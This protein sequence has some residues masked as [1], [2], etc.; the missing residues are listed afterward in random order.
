MLLICL[1]FSILQILFYGRHVS[2]MAFS[3]DDEKNYSL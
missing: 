2:F 3:D 1:Y